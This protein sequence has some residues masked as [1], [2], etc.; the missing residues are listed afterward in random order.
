MPEFEVVQ[1]LAADEIKEGIV[2]KI[3]EALWAALDKTCNLYQ[4]SYPKFAGRI[5]S[6]SGIDIDLD[7]YRDHFGDE[8]LK[9][10]I[11]LDL[12]LEIPLTPPNVFRHD[13]AQS[14]PVLTETDDGS[15]E[16]KAVI[17]KRPRGRPKK[18][19]REE[20]NEQ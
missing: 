6:G 16:Q 3:T 8:I 9:D 4:I 20:G 5:K 7:L 19:G 1:P 11:H 14:I 13:T 17:Y 10:H 2:F 15:V 18:I 12:D